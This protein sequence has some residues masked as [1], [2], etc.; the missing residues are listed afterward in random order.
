MLSCYAV[1]AV[2]ALLIG[3]DATIAGPADPLLI[4]LTGWPPRPILA[5]ID[6]RMWHTHPGGVPGLLET[7]AT[8]LT[9]PAATTSA[10]VQAIGR[11][12]HR[13]VTPARLIAWA[14]LYDDLHTDPTGLHPVR[15]IDAVDIDQRVFQLWRHADDRAGLVVVD[16]TPDPEDTPATQPAL[17]RLVAACHRTAAPRHPC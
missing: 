4:A 12:I 6:A 14:V 13:T 3:A 1:Q 11:E 9:D 17:A 7:V 8:T 15:R 16:D 10:A 2:T 5:P